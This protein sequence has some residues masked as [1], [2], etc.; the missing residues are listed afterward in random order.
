MSVRDG[1]VDTAFNQ[2]RQYGRGSVAVTARLLEV[3]ATCAGQVVSDDQRQ[4]LPRHA[5]MVYEDSHDAVPQQR[6][7]DDIRARWQ[8]AIRA[9]GAEGHVAPSPAAG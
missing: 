6:D 4:S 5:N 3:I 2:I 8:A 9:P 1:V 7:H